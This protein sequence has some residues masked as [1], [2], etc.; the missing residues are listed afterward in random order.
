LIQRSG[1]GRRRLSGFCYHIKRT[2]AGTIRKGRKN[3]KYVG[4][5]FERKMG[6]TIILHQKA[7]SL[8]GS[9]FLL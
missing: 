3:N 2:G 6:K 7:L 1:F 8:D 4:T 9:A 5:L